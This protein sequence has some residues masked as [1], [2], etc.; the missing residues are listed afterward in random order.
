MAGSEDICV[1]ESV[2]EQAGVNG[3]R[4][5]VGKPEVLTDVAS[6]VD[7]EGTGDNKTAATTDAGQVS[8]PSL[9]TPSD[10]EI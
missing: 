5:Q 6:T 10:S 3:I 7:G 9:S 1:P 2:S 4:D 8:V